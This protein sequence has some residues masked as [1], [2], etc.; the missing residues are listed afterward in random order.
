MHASMVSPVCHTSTVNVIQLAVVSRGIAMT[1]QRAVTL[2]A[3]CSFMVECIMAVSERLFVD[4][5]TTT[6]D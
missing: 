2:L 5:I 6:A 4:S 1:R 3:E